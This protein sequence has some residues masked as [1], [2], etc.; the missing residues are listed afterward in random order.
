[1]INQP[2]S[3][4]SAQLSILNVGDEPRIYC[5][6]STNTKDLAQ[7]NHVLCTGID[8]N[9]AIEAQGED[10]RS[11]AQDLKK[12]CVQSG[13]SAEIPT[14]LK[15]KLSSIARILNINW[16]ERS[17]DSQARLICSRGATCPREPS[18]YQGSAIGANT[19]FIA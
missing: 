19:T 15:A 16:V 3:G 17:I 18:C 2:V 10:A 9:P 14:A 1:M 5:C 7:N 12:V 6:E 11:I 4:T 8:L 13:G